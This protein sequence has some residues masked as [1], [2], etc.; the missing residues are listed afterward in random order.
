[1]GRFQDSLHRIDLNRFLSQIVDLNPLTNGLDLWQRCRSRTN[2]A[3]L[4]EP[5]QVGVIKA[6]IAPFV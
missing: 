3:I 1:M 6:L 5:D 4:Q 2:V